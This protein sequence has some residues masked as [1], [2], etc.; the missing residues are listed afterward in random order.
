[1]EYVKNIM[2]PYANMHK[3]NIE[4]HFNNTLKTRYDKNQIQQC[5]INLYKNGIEAM[6]DTGGTLSITISEIKNEIMIKVSD[7]GVGMTKEEVSRLGR[8]FYSTKTEGTGLGM[9]MVYSTIN[10]VKGKI[11]VESEKG[12]GTTF[13]I[14]IPV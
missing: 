2:V 1:T 10:K 6:K 8:P 12:K 7:T 11:H 14:T 5:L 13:L 9:L 4:F 3:V